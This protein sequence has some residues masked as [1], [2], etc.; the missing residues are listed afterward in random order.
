MKKMIVYAMVAMMA[1]SI[2]ACG[3]KGDANKRGDQNTSVA[4]DSQQIPNPWQDCDSITDAQKNVGFDMN[5]PDK[6]GDYTQAWI[7]TMDKEMIQVDY[8]SGKD[9]LMIRK[10][11]SN[12]DPSGDYN[13][14]NKEETV[15]VGDLSVTMKG[16]DDR[17]NLAVWNDGEYSYSVYASAGMSQEM[18]AEIVSQVQ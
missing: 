14:Y 15:N 17:M 13:A 4:E 7:Q 6:V 1:F 2:C 12:D 5:V 18:L 10:A 9:E 3:S 11:A 16:N 8:T